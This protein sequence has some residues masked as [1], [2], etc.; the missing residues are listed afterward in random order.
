[1][2]PLLSKWLGGQNSLSV[3][4]GR[5]FL[6]VFGRMLTC[7]IILVVKILELAKSDNTD[8]TYSVMMSVHP[9][10]KS[11]ERLIKCLH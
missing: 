3:L 6:D 8:S 5:S 1:M 11:C 9:T 2:A 4:L 7:D 10:S